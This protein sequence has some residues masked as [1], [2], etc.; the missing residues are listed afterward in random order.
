MCPR[1]L[2]KASAGWQEFL[3]ALSSPTLLSRFHPAFVVFAAGIY[4]CSLCACLVFSMLKIIGICSVFRQ[5]AMLLVMLLGTAT[6]SPCDDT[7]F[8]HAVVMILK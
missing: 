7:S 6:Q 8:A 4:L 3:P 2:L 1:Y 5:Q